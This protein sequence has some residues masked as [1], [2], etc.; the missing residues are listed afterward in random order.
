M[1]PTC[2]QE[3][4][5]VSSRSSQRSSSPECL[6]RLKGVCC[7]RRSGSPSVCESCSV[8]CFYWFFSADVSLRSLGL[9]ASFMTLARW[10]YPS[11]D[12]T[13]LLLPQELNGSVLISSRVYKQTFW[14][15]A[16]LEQSRVFIQHCDLVRSGRPS[17]G[18]S[19][20]STGLS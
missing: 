2:L 7:E 17:K 12:C 4:N 16:E 10:W 18:Q 1:L 20:D 15:I 5:S 14:Q 13:A 9:R 6:S 8:F 3:V 19:S 11:N